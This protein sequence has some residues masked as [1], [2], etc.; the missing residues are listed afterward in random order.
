[1]QALLLGLSRETCFLV[2]GE[3][4]KLRRITEALHAQKHAQSSLLKLVGKR[5]SLQLLV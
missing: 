5:I 3:R 4:C 2:G 1:M